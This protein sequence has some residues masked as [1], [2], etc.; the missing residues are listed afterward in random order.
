MEENSLPRVRPGCLPLWF[1]PAARMVQ[2][3]LDSSCT[4]RRSSGTKGFQLVSIFCKSCLATVYRSLYI[5]IIWIEIFTQ[6]LREFLFFKNIQKIHCTGITPTI[7]NVGSRQKET[8]TKCRTVTF[9]WHLLNENSAG[10]VA[11]VAPGPLLGW[12]GGLPLTNY[13]FSFY[14]ILFFSH[15]QTIL[16]S[17]EY[18]FRLPQVGE[19]PK[20]VTMKFAFEGSDD[21]PSFRIDSK[22]VACR[23]THGSVFYLYF[24]QVHIIAINRRK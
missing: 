7:H 16:I 14:R 4:R 19:E 15:I 1:L 11:P 13:W 23:K 5:R 18:I 17:M 24:L 20:N 6:A 8:K 9:R 12:T 3:C 10:Q 2:V 21:N 22:I